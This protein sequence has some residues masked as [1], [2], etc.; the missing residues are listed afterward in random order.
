MLGVFGL[1]KREDKRE[2]EKERPRDEK[3]RRERERDSEIERKKELI[4]YKVAFM[5]VDIMTNFV[6]N[7]WYL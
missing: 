5:L 7:R 3:R 6:I 4:P 1:M 2:T